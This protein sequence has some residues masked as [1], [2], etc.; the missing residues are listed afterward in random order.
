MKDP[1]KGTAWDAIRRVRERTGHFIRVFNSL[2]GWEGANV[3]LTLVHRTLGAEEYLREKKKAVCFGVSQVSPERETRAASNLHQDPWHYPWI[4]GTAREEAGLGHL[5]CGSE[6]LRGLGS[7]RLVP[8]TPGRRHGERM[9]VE[10]KKENP[11]LI[12]RS[13]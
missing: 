12:L 13:G 6:W 8:L 10:K 2:N 7:N 11:P 1:A 9:D 4:W 3:R 5:D